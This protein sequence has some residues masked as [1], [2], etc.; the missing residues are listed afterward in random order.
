MKYVLVIDG[1]VVQTQ[2]YPADGF[3][4][5]PID[6]VPG[7]LYDGTSF[8]LPSTFD[9]PLTPAV[10]TVRQLILGLLGDGWIS[11]TAA[12]AWTQGT[13][14]A[15]IET[16]VLSLPETDRVQARITLR[17]MREVH[18]AD[19]LTVML[20]TAAG[21]NGTALNDSFRRWALL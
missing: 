16:A 21:L 15:A 1:V 4:D 11:E 3:V 10:V 12:E 9:E 14:P 5:A 18:L 20:A 13:L 8:S 19:P 17:S 7:C 2:P 6:V